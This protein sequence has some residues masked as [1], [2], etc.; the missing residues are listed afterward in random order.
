MKEYTTHCSECGSLLL[1][2]EIAYS[3]S[4]S[5]VSAQIELC[6]YC[7]HITGHVD[8]T[9]LDD[10]SFDDELDEFFNDVDMFDG[11]D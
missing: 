4:G 9:E 1:E 11:D 10:V 8:L 7:A 5:L 6:E 3:E 2:D